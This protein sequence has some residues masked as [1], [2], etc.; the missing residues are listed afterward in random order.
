MLK[1]SDRTPK[2]TRAKGKLNHRST[3]RQRNGHGVPLNLKQWES[4]I[5]TSPT[6]IYIAKASG[7]YDA[8]FISP[9]IRMQLG[10]EPKGPQFE[11]EPRY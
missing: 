7:D 10:Y 4:L 11:S 6:V 9:N 3:P 8:I 5:A 2:P 1:P